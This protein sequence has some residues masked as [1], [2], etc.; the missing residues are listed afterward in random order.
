[1][2]YKSS[3]V[4]TP[5]QWLREVIERQA[6]VDR[7]KGIVD[8]MEDEYPPYPPTIND[9]NSEECEITLLDLYASYSSMSTGFCCGI[10][11]FT[12]FLHLL[13]SFSFD[14]HFFNMWS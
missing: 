13:I 3:T 14:N 1:M 8:T 6:T 5:S 7:C 4:A 10:C 9:E 2:V 11:R 12:L